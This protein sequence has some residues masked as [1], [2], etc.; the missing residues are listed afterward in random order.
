MTCIKWYQLMDNLSLEN[1]LKSI[2]RK[3]SIEFSSISN[4]INLERLNNN[5]VKISFNQIEEL[6][7]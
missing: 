2:F 5:P 7:L 1:D 4:D 6:F 3:A